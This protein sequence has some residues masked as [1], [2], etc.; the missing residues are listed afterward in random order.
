ME[1]QYNAIALCSLKKGGKSLSTVCLVDGKVYAS[2]GTW[3]HLSWSEAY[4]EKVWIPG[5]GDDGIL[6]TGEIEYR[7]AKNRKELTKMYLEAMKE[8]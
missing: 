5:H 8:V 7:V 1:R 6:Y 4:H 2:N 3:S